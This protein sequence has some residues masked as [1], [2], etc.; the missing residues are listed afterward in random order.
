MYSILLPTAETL[1]K[2]CAS[3][4]K[5]YAKLCDSQLQQFHL[6]PCEIDMLILLS[7]NP[8]IHNAKEIVLYLGVAKSLVA[9]SVESLVTRN[10]LRVEMDTKDR[11][12]QNLYV[13]EEA[14]QIVEIILKHREEFT[15]VILRSIDEKELRIAEKVI[16]QINK[17]INEFMKG[18]ITV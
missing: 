17:N 8:N 6:S 16:K 12:I 7:N 9:R 14:S 3:F 11:R 10:L 13:S 1:V 4:R 2:Q 18:D 15:D 5:G